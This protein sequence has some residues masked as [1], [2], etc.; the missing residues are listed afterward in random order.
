M[1]IVVTVT[2]LQHMCNENTKAIPA[3]MGGSWNH[4]KIFSKIP[5]EHNG[6][7]RNEETAVILDNVY[8][9][10]ESTD[11]QIRN[12]QHGKYHCMYHKLKLQENSNTI[13][14]RNRVFQVYNCIYLT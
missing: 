1:F 2:E 5:V 8:V 12:T 14:L 13:Y 7:A 6:K 11:V 10:S 9:I 4:P 3:V